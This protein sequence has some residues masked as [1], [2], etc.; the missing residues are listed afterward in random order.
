AGVPEDV[1]ELLRTI[2]AKIPGGTLVPNVDDNFS[3]VFD[4]VASLL[5]QL[6]PYLA[7]YNFFQALLEIIMCIIDVICALINPFSL[8]GAIIRLF[9]R[10]IPNFLSIFPFIALLVM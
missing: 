7:I 4:A 6:G 9:K 2:F 5:N 10:C 1:I 3:N 8:I